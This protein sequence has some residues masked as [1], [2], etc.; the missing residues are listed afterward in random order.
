MSLK[1]WQIIAGVIAAIVVLYF[2]RSFYYEGFST[3]PHA[4][5]AS[6]ESPSFDTV[7]TEE[8]AVHTIDGSSEGPQTFSK[9]DITL[10]LETPLPE[11]NFTTVP[12]PQEYGNDAYMPIEEVTKA[13]TSKR[14]GYHTSA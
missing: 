13:P 14:K 10:A 7:I 8:P 1:S 9:Q 12:V 4:H 11:E 5:E 6:T 3:S 2:L